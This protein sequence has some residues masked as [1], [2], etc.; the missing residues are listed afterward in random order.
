M[1]ALLWWTGGCLFCFVCL[2]GACIVRKAFSWRAAGYS[3]LGG[4]I[5]FAL[6]SQP[7]YVFLKGIIRKIEAGGAS[8][9]MHIAVYLI[10]NVV[11]GVI[12]FAATLI[13]VRVKKIPL[14]TGTTVYYALMVAFLLPW[15]V[16]CFVMMLFGLDGVAMLGA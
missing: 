8:P 6:C 16:Y 3:L 4:V 12:A 1:N 5:S 9:L 13:L 15:Y 2:L 7:L 11:F 14:T 10:A